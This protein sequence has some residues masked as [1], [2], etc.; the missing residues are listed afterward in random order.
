V[1][2]SRTIR[3]NW[4]RLLSP[5]A[6]IAI[7]QVGAS[8]G[9]IP[10]RI[11]SGPVQILDTFGD[12]VA[13][14]ELGEHLAVSLGRVV[15]GIAIGGTAGAVLALLAGVS[16][17]GEIIVDAPVQMLRTLP[18]LALVPLLILWFGIGETPKVALVSLAVAFPVYMTLF[19]GIRGVDVKLIEMARVQRLSRLRQIRHVIL[20]GALPDALVGLRFALAVSWLS[21]VAAEQVNATAGIGYMMMQAREFMRTDVIVVGLLVYAILGLATDIIVRMLEHHLLAWRPSFIRSERS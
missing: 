17:T 8:T 10:P 21:L 7:W 1:P 4:T 11:L 3:K 18:F 15:K 6:L 20:P 16:R 2:L 12:L 14:G 5:L 13:S 19:A 9:L